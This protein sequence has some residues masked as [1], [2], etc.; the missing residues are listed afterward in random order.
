MSTLLSVLQLEFDSD[1]TFYVLFFIGMCM[2][3]TKN[4]DADESAVVRFVQGHRVVD[5]S[6]YCNIARHGE[7]VCA[8]TVLFLLVF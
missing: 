7:L 6:A 8:F 5:A 3:L 2:K 1:L 4:E